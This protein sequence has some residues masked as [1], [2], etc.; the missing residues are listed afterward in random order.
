MT[1]QQPT[2]QVFD[3]VVVGFAMLVHGIR[4][5]RRTYDTVKEMEEG[6][7][8]LQA[9][10]FHQGWDMPIPTEYMV[11]FKTD[12]GEEEDVDLSQYYVPHLTKGDAA[13]K[14]ICKCGVAAWRIGKTELFANMPPFIC[15]DCK[16]SD[17]MDEVE[18]LKE[19][20]SDPR[21]LPQ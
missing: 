11:R 16:Q 8:R 4:E 15:D 9:T 7:K 1:L 17:T 18:Y 19:I 13:N 20:D 5:Q 10:A 21:D 14:I 3:G 6:N 2:Q 12:S